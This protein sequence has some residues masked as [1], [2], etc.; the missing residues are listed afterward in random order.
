MSSASHTAPVRW[1]RV[2]FSTAFDPLDQGRTS[3]MPSTERRTRRTIKAVVTAGLTVLIAASAF[4]SAAPAEPNTSTDKKE[5]TC[6]GGGK[7][8]QEIDVEITTTLPDGRK[9][10][11]KAKARCGEDGE[12]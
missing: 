7:V 6:I 2:L 12:W 5:V 4:A 1:R 11:S 8:G 10:K 3:N 9:G